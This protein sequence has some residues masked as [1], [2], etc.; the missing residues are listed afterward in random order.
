MANSR[1]AKA[2]KRL[3]RPGTSDRAPIL[4]NRKTRTSGAFK[5]GARADF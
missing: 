4:N 2:F 1:R 5:R 3:S